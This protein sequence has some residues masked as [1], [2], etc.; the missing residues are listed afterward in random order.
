MAGWGGANAGTDRT[1]N[2]PNSP[3]RPAHSTE[4][5]IA[6]GPELTRGA[7]D[8]LKKFPNLKSVSLGPRP[9]ATTNC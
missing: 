2:S 6:P 1:P 8:A 7:L 9:G 3:C 5:K 4:L